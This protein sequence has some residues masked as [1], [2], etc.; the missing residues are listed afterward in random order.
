MSN[1]LKL[2]HDLLAL[3]Y[4]S[5]ALFYVR[6]RIV[7]RQDLYVFVLYDEGCELWNYAGIGGDTAA[8]IFFFVN[9]YS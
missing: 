3:L 9:Y 8:Y 7:K 6:R 1:N 5:E 2:M 4:P